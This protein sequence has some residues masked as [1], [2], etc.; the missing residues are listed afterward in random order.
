MFSMTGYGRGDCSDATKNF[1]VDIRSINHR[2]SDIVVK[3]PRH[4][5]YLEDKIKKYVKGHVSRGRI[6]VGINLEYI[7]EDIFE[8]EVNMELAQGYKSSI[9]RLAGELG[10]ANDLSISK[11]VEFPDVLKAKKKEEDESLVWDTLKQALHRALENLVSMRAEEGLKLK[12]DI[13]LKV[14][15]IENTLESISRRSPDVVAEYKEK[16]AKRI[17]D[18]LEGR[19]EIDESRLANE[20]AYFADKS[21]VDEEVVRLKS[22][23]GQL[24]KTMDSAES[25][26]KK[27][28]FIVQEMNR[29][30]NT[31]GSKSGDI[32]I[33]NYVVEIKSRIEEIRE[34]VQ[35]IE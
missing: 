7:S 35:N 10:V 23:M 8:I 14:D 28:D 31:I 27:L 34:Q 26:G 18:L 15:S 6:E 33:T 2:Y 11:I 9:E 17:D 16:L 30:T 22:H 12:E 19:V 21:N 20:V 13:E 1:T 4:I 25:K 3:M 5:S 24:K 32:E 29:E